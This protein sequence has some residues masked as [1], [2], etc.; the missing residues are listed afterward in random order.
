MT[1]DTNP[2][3]QSLEVSFP[4]TI[5]I[6]VKKAESLLEFSN[7]FFSQLVRH[8]VFCVVLIWYDTCLEM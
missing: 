8:C 3:D 5:S 4:L 7:L 6:L 2:I 1:M